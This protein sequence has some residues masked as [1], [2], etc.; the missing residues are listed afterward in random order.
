[1]KQAFVVEDNKDI[2]ALYKATLLMINYEAECISDGKA[3]LDRLED[4]S[5]DLIILDM[6]L[7][8]VSGHYLY[9]KIRATPKLDDV[10]IIIMTANTIAAQTLADKLGARDHLL[11]KP[12]APKELQ[13]LIKSL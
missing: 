12:V 11:L 7:P 13:D 6:N 8:N 1:M 5:P 10:P 4:V 3:A 9:Q 2:M